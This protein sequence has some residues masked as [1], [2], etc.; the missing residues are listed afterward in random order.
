MGYR[1]SPDRIHIAMLH[2]PFGRVC[3][4]NTNKNTNSHIGVGPISRRPALCG[5]LPCRQ[6]KK[7][8]EIWR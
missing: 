1:W 5:T 3:S 2:E 7:Y 8:L 4:T 6:N